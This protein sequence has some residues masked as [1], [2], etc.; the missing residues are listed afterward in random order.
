MVRVQLLWLS[1]FCIE[2]IKFEYGQLPFI[3]GL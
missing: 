1:M 3:T 2:Q